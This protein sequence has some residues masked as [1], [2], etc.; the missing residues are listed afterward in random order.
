MASMPFGRS[1]ILKGGKGNDKVCGES[2]KD[3]LKGGAGKDKQVQ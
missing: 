2:G 3:T 1:D